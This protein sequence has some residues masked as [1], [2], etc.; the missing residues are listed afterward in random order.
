MWRAF[1]NSDS[2][3]R[4][5]SVHACDQWRVY[6]LR[7]SPDLVCFPGKTSSSTAPSAFFA[8][9]DRRCIAPSAMEIT[10]VKI[11]LSDDER[12]KAY[13]TITID[14]CFV[15]QGLRLTYSQKKGYFLFMPG[16]KKADGT[17]ESRSRDS[18]ASPLQT[19]YCFYYKK[20]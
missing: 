1:G 10:R 16:K 2:K 14:D 6:E 15:I 18:C 3:A 20:P 8:S 7:P 17:Y 4:L 13:A 9:A 5:K 19:Q 12:I 11:R